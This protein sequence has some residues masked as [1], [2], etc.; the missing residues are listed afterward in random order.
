MKRMTSIGEILFDLYPEGNKLGGAPF[1]FI[2]HIRKLT[3]AGN[4]ISRIGNDKY[5]KEILEFL[6]D[7]NFPADY[8]QVDEKKPTGTASPQL[9]SQ[10]IPKWKIEEDTA[11]DFIELTENVNDLIEN[12]TD[13]VYF[14]TLAQREKES[15]ETIQSL[16]HKKGK[17]YFC[18][19]NIRQNFYS[20]ELLEECLLAADML[21]LNSDEMELVSS[22]LLNERFDE[23]KTPQK[24][25][26]KYSIDLLCITKG[27]EGAILFCGGEKNKY[28]INLNKEEVIDTVGAGDA[29]AAILC[30]GYL[31]NWSLEKINK[32]AS[33]FAS[34]I[35]MINGALPDNDSVY[36]K[37]KKR[38]EQTK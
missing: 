5:G 24:V 23:N 22:L 30:L 8:I 18:D 4:F 17:K 15:R 7:K 33:E 32:L 1:N 38:I 25:M 34:E 35:V 11:Y 13:C 9:S 29:Y 20:K 6:K 26:G 10:K 16:F 31:E 28:E 19:L 21:K 3:G 2:Y 37:I 36:D 14:G 12:Q 27:S